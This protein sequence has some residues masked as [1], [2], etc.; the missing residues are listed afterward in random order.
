MNT[1]RNTSIQQHTYSQQMIVNYNGE[2]HDTHAFDWEFMSEGGKHAIF[3][4]NPKRRMRDD[5]FFKA[6]VLR[7]EKDAF[8]FRTNA[9]KPNKK[10]DSKGEDE[11]EDDNDA[12]EDANCPHLSLFRTLFEATGSEQHNMNIYVDHP[13]RI[14]LDGSFLSDLKHIAIKS[15]KILHSRQ[16]DWDMES[17]TVP[18]TKTF[19]MTSTSTS[20]ELLPNYRTPNAISVE[21]KPKAGYLAI[22]PL[23]HPNHRVKHHISRF[24][25]LQVLNYEGIISKGWNK[26]SELGLNEMSRYDPLDLFSCDIERVRRAIGALF[27]H[28]QNNLSIY[29]GDH[30]LHS[31]EKGLGLTSLDDNSGDCNFFLNCDWI[32]ENIFGDIAHTDIPSND[33]NRRSKVILEK[34]LGDALSEILIRDP[35]LKQ[36]LDLQKQFDILDVDGAILVYN[37]LLSLCGGCNTRAEELIDSTDNFDSKDDFGHMPSQQLAD[38]I[39]FIKCESAT[40][41]S[42]ENTENLYTQG[43]ELVTN[44]SVNDCTFL[45]RNW[46]R[47]LAVCDISFFVVIKPFKDNVYNEKMQD[48]QLHSG[49]M[50]QYIIKVVDYDLKPAKKLRNREK[51]ESKIALHKSN[52]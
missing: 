32:I 41:S 30:L 27:D 33:Q 18:S 47:S 5:D 14:E 7:I 11:D 4:F 46:L 21:I 8:Q 49:K 12:V 23:V 19:T 13:I 45:L 36:L 50:L 29:F 10:G 48:I 20:V 17:C 2:T 52:Y 1:I 37:R 3:A 35:F 31:R 51:S 34:E 42:Q 25:I 15:G 9:V 6:K 40:T 26:G 39:G 22:S 16:T 24:Q 43:K 44:L 38:L 28:P